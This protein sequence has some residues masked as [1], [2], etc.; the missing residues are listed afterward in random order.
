MKLVNVPIE[1]I[2]LSA[3]NPRVAPG[4]VTE[5]AESIKG[6]GI[7]QPCIGYVTTD[8]V[9]TTV[10]LIAGSRRYTAARIAGL[11]TIPM[12][13]H[14]K[15]SSRIQRMVSLVENLHRRDTTPIE[16]GNAFEELTKEGMTQAQ[17]AKQTGISIVTVNTRLKLVR[18]LHPE[19]QDYVHR[20]K[21]SIV[22]AL[23]LCD[24]QPPRKQL[25][26]ITRDTSHG[27]TGTVKLKNRP[28]A[29]DVVM[30]WF[31]EARAYYRD[32]LFPSSLTVL[33]KIV[34]AIEQR[35]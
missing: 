29:N 23:F 27:H 34:K 24:V 2:V 31:T 22:D 9:E 15:P 4:D 19:L 33:K 18:K 6:V 20:G 13:V 30:T 35:T 3:V 11:R 32:G 1:N 16:D 5:L 21:M 17:I 7:L 10:V 26:R 25:L 12:L 8:D 28:S 14:S